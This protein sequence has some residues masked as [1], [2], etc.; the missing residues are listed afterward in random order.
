MA[1]TDLVPEEL[2]RVNRRVEGTQVNIVLRPFASSIPMADFSFA[3]GNLLYAGFLLGWIPKSEASSVAVLLL[4]FVTPLQLFASV[5]GFLS[6]D[7]GGGTAFGLFGSSWLVAGIGLL[8]TG[9]TKPSAANGLFMLGLAVSLVLLA[10]IIF[11]SKPLLGALLAVA[12]L[13]T[14]GMAGVEYGWH[15]AVPFTTGILGLI[16]SVMGAYAGLAFLLEDVRLEPS[17]LALRWGTGKK[18]MEGRTDDQISLL[19]REAGIR[20]E[21]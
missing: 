21:L 2:S 15:G 6:R 18:A 1:Q 16:L 13:R 4:A 11:S 7:T 20:R 5:M 14:I 3:I 8:R 12:V 17:P 10:G 19:T 9:G